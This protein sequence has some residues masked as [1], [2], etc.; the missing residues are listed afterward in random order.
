MRGRKPT[1]ITSATS[2]LQAVPKPPAWLSKAAKLEWKRA[3]PDLVSRKV[4]TDVDM[5]LVEAFCV[6]LGRVR[7]IEAIIQASGGSIDP[8]LFRMQDKAMQTARQIGAEIGATP[9]SRSR[10]TMR[11]DDAN[12]DL[13]FLD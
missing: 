4:L 2:T 8:K 5:G 1:S 10:P 3:L 7:E 12:E 13:S 11:D 6:S 9:V